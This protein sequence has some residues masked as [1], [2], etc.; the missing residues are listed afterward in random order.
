MKKELLLSAA[1]ILLL[2]SC[3]P[4]SLSGK[5]ETVTRGMDCSYEKVFIKGNIDVEVSDEAN[6]LTITGDSNLLKLVKVKADKKTVKII[7]TA[8]LLRDA[9][10]PRV[11]VILPFGPWMNTLNMEGTS[12]FSFGR[13][14]IGPD[15]LIDTK[16]SNYV[17]AVMAMVNLTI[18]A[19]GSDNILVDCVC[20]YADIDAKGSCTIASEKGPIAA[21]KI[22]I[23]TFGTSVAYIEAP[24]EVFGAAEGE[25]IIYTRGEHD[26]VKLKAKD[27]AK[28]I[29]YDI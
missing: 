2:A 4:R 9:E 22:K 12:S 25:S 20:D 27:K 1:A 7:A 10:S 29:P 21:D 28:I 18:K 15:L 6:V 3:G 13:G 23:F 24:R 11:K 8:S 5:V 19:D 26:Y 17:Y 14:D 16:G